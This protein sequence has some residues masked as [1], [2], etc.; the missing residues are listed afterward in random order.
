MS[1]CATYYDVYSVTAM[2][3][4]HWPAVY[5][6]ASRVGQNI[7]FNEKKLNIDKTD[8]YKNSWRYFRRKCASFF[9]RYC[10]GGWLIVLVVISVKDKKEVALTTSA[11]CS[12][13]YGTSLE[14]YLLSFAYCFCG[15]DMILYAR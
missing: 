12:E 8:D 9:S 10:G 6:L 4:C 13:T 11:L 1:A 15:K 3:G 2:Q 7:V 5:A 14:D